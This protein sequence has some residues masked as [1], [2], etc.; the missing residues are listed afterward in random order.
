MDTPVA[1]VTNSYGFPAH[2]D[3]EIKE[4]CDLVRSS[5]AAARRSS[6]SDAANECH[7]RLWSACLG[8]HQ[9][10]D[11]M[12]VT[13]DPQKPAMALSVYSFLR[14]SGCLYSGALRTGLSWLWSPG[15]ARFVPP[16]GSM[17]SSTIFERNWSRLCTSKWPAMENFIDNEEMASNELKLLFS[18]NIA[19]IVEACDGGTF[20]VNCSN[21]SRRADA[22]GVGAV[23][24]FSQGNPRSNHKAFAAAS[25]AVDK[26][27]ALVG[28]AQLVELIRR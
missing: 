3:L 23:P 15:I 24:A 7:R 8:T 10:P 12:L 14:L 13:V 9:T 5:V 26:E 2:R 16:N 20:Y 22:H 18:E 21:A 25:E 28:F 17:A 4:V 19:S 6:E 11:T 27:R 1:N